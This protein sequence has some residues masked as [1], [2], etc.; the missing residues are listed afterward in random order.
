MKPNFGGASSNSSV[1]LVTNRKSGNRHAMKVIHTV[2]FSFIP[3][4]SRMVRREQE[5]LSVL[6]HPHVLE[7]QLSRRD[8]VHSRIMFIFPEMEGGNIFD[9][10]VKN[11]QPQN[12]RRLNNF[13]PQVA[14]DL[15][16]GLAYIH[17]KDIVHRDLKPENVFLAEAFSEGEQKYPTVVIGDFGIARLPGEKR[18]EMYDGG[19]NHWLSPI[20]F[21]D[22]T[23]AKTDFP[24]DL[25]GVALII[26]FMVAGLPKPWGQAGAPEDPKEI[27]QLRWERLEEL[28][29][30]AECTD[31]LEGFL[32]DHPRR[33]RTLEDTENHRWIHNGITVNP[34]EEEK[35]VD[36][37]P[38]IDLHAEPESGDTQ[39]EFDD[40]Y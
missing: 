28:N 40:E 39:V 17:S 13:A 29:I 23:E 21:R 2:K 34:N 38:V 8:D 32:V 22:P 9:F 5:A 6:K 7:L 37:A 27:N 4:L 11:R 15:L 16:S 10:V 31:F 19:S 26:W 25:W 14:K 20:S 33:C 30:T 36:F 18:T 3:A 24:I 12:Q 35:G 1:Y